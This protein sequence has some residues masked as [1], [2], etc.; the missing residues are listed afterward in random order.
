MEE[1]SEWLMDYI[2]INE[3][4]YLYSSIMQLKLLSKS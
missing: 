3:E 2:F 1:Y 4:W